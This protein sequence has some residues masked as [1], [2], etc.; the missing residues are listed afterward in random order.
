M[1]YYVFH[2][3]AIFMS[4]LLQMCA[5]KNIYANLYQNCPKILLLKL[6]CH[7][8]NLQLNKE[9]IIKLTETEEPVNC[10]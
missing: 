5:Y 6:D 4:I 8:I 7:H 9:D 1:L 10:V 3:N 2:R